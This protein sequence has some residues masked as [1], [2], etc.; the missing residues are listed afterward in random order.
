M[1]QFL[2]A[3]MVICF[4][5]S[6]PLNIIKSLRARTAKGKSIAF[7]FLVEGGYLAGIGAKL[8]GGAVNYVFILYVLNA[9][10]VA[11][12]II[13]YFRNRA[14]DAA[15]S[16]PRSSVRRGS[17]LISECQNP[18]LH[19]KPFPPLLPPRSKGFCFAKTHFRSPHSLSYIINKELVVPYFL[20][21]IYYLH[22][23]VL[24]IIMCIGG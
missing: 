8:S 5:F 19:H 4:G 21:I 18:R 11:A 24:C 3:L 14:L 10:M 7:L 6:W 15:A 20:L 16:K 9:L 23:H 17:A 2:E 22:N 1:S 13:L 12:D